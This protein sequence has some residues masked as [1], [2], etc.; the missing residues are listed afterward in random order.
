M[1]SCLKRFFCRKRDEVE[2]IKGTYALELNDNKYYVGESNDV[3]RRV[4]VHE[5]GQGSAWTKKYEVL[6][7]VEPIDDENV[8][9]TELILNMRDP[10][11]CL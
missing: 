5:N 9:F 4:W 2:K 11:I 3:K 1:F 8:D 10:K 7:Q 6:K